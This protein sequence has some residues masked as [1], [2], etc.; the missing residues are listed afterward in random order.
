[1]RIWTVV[2]GEPSPVDGEAVRL[3]RKCILAGVLAA[4]GHSVVSFNGTVEH[5]TKTQR[6]SESCVIDGP[7]GMKLAFLHGR[8]YRRNIS[9]DRIMNNWD[10]AKSFTALAETLEKPDVIVCSYPPIELAAAVSRFA[11]K[12]NIPYIVDYRDQWPDIIA[13]VAPA[14]VR[15]LAR[16]LMWPWYASARMSAR[17]AAGLVGITQPFLDWALG[18]AGRAKGAQDRV[19]HLVGSPSDSSDQSLEAA[20]R[21]WDDHNVRGDLTTLTFAG[22]LS[23]RMDLETLVAGALLL[24]EDLRAKIKIVICGKGEAEDRLR[25]MAADAPHILFAGWRN[26]AELRA[27]M[28]RASIGLLPYRSEQDFMMSFPNKVGEYLSGGLPILTCLKGEVTRLIE[29]EHCGILYEEDN[30]QS[31]AARLAELAA[32]RPDLPAMAAAAKKVYERDFDARRIYDDYADYV[33][34]IGRG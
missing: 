14:P 5:V 24:P 12:H 2:V 26:Q 20:E 6:F 23:R 22:T 30:P 16:L 31:C 21:F 1:M 7:N 27:L 4:R 13:D 10:V 8:L 17:Y 9:P 34:Q 18:F 11:R 25:A 3:H 32:G 28:K 29:A 15:P 33:E 19:F